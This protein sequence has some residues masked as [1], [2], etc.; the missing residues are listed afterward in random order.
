[1]NILHLLVIVM[2]NNSR[3]ISAI[4]FPDEFYNMSNKE[5]FFLSFRVAFLP[6]R[7]IFVQRK[8]GYIAQATKLQYYM[9]TTDYGCCCVVVYRQ[10]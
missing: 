1:M 5:N 7:E 3:K 9:H 6:K 8:T 4:F 2:G 10:T